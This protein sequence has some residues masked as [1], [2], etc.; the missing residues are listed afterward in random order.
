M[1]QGYTV[2]GAKDAILRQ[3]LRTI[4]RMPSLTGMRAARQ[5]GASAATRPTIS[6]AALASHKV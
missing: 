2:Y 3:V 5:A 4:A 1:V 6:A